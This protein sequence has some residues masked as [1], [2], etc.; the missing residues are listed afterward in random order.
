MNNNETLRAFPGRKSS[1]PERLGAAG[2]AAT[3]CQVACLAGLPLGLLGVPGQVPFLQ[4]TQ[5]VM[6]ATK[7][8][9]QSLE[10][11]ANVITSA[12]DTDSITWVPE[13]WTS[14]DRVAVAGFF[15]KHEVEIASLRE[16]VSHAH[17]L[18][19]HPLLKLDTARAVCNVFVA[20][21]VISREE[22]SGDSIAFLAELLRAVSLLPKRQDAP[23]WQSVY[24]SALLPMIQSGIQECGKLKSLV[25][26]DSLLTALES[27]LLSDLD[28]KLDD[29]NARVVPALTIGVARVQLWKAAIGAWE[30]KRNNG[31]LPRSLDEL[32]PP[33]TPRYFGKTG[34]EFDW[35]LG[36][37]AVSVSWGI[38]GRDR[39]QIAI[40]LYDRAK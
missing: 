19:E 22:D 27:Q 26:L 25:E 38:P 34:V 3:L 13:A 8:E 6:H 2:N 28:S 10:E 31:R 11:L 17:E 24:V 9:Y 39:T 5:S 23:G 40:E 32:D 15:L 14:E 4:Q 37:D 36:E 18:S 20:G 29:G 33:H 16:L 21:A 35:Q 1:N 12:A 7:Q 30:F